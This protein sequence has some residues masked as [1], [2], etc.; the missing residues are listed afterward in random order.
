MKGKSWLILRLKS[1]VIDIFNW[2]VHRTCNH[3]LG[4]AT[5]FVGG[6]KDTRPITEFIEFLRCLVDGRFRSGAI[7]DLCAV[8]LQDD[9][10]N[11]VTSRRKRR[12]RRRLHVCINITVRTMA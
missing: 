6:K 7:E 2:Q 12:K 5:L 11:Y 4:D 10:P 8:S 3:D 1:G 9:I